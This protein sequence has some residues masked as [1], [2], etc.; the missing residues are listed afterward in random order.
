M[1]RLGLCFISNG[2]NILFSIFNLFHVKFLQAATESQSFRNVITS[3]REIILYAD[4]VSQVANI[5]CI[6][7]LASYFPFF[8]NFLI[9]IFTLNLK[10]MSCGTR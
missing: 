8:Y 4:I 10:E 9:L 3:P 6:T 5:T 7:L 2:Y 1:D